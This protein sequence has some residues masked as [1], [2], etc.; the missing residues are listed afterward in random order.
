MAK[1]K[2]SKKSSRG[3][4]YD[5]GAALQ[6]IKDNP[7]LMK[8]AGN[9]MGSQGAG[10]NNTAQ[11]Q[12]NIDKRFPGTKPIYGTE[13]NLP[14][15]SKVS[16]LTDAMR[17]FTN[18]EKPSLY[19]K[20]G[21]SYEGGGGMAGIG[22]FD[23]VADVGAQ[24]IRD[25][26]GPDMSSYYNK[27]KQVANTTFGGS[28]TDDVVE[29]YN[30]M[31]R[32]NHVKR[33]DITG[34]S[35]LTDV[36]GGLNQN[37]A[38]FGKGYMATQNF[39]AAGAIAAVDLIGQI[40]K[41]FNTGRKKRRLNR[42]I[43][44]ANNRQAV[45]LNNSIDNVDTAN[46]QAILENYIGAYG[47]PIHIAKSK[48]GTFTAAANKHN[49][50]VQEFA[51]KVLAN[52]DNYSPA[53]V[54]KANFARNAAKWH[55]FGGPIDDFTNGVTIIDNG[56]THEAN[57]YNGVPMGVAPDGQPN[58][59]EEG[60][61][62][63]KDY[64]YSNRLKVP[65]AVRQKYK[66]RGPKDMTFAE[67][68]K[69]AQKESSERPNDPISKNGL[70][71]SAQILAAA[72]EG[73]K[74]DMKNKA[75]KK[76]AKGG[77]LFAYGD[78]PYYPY[79][80]STDNIEVYRAVDAYNNSEDSEDSVES[81]DSDVKTSAITRPVPITPVTTGKSKINDTLGIIKSKYSNKEALKSKIDRGLAEYTSRGDR[82]S[83]KADLSALRY[84][85]T[86][87]NAGAVLSD[88]LGYTNRPHL[89][90][91]VP[92]AP[93]IRHSPLGNYLPKMSIDTRY[94]ANALAQQAAA[95]R[96]ALMQSNSPSRNAAILAADFNAQTQLGDLLRKDQLSQYDLDIKRAEFNR[97]TDQANSQMGLTAAEANARNLL[98]VAQMAM[99]QDEYN[100]KRKLA[101]GM[102]KS[103]NAKALAENIS[104][105]GREADAI[106]W[107]DMYIKFGPALPDYMRPSG[108]TDEEWA[109]CK[110]SY[111]DGYKENITKAKKTKACGGKIRR[112]NKGFTF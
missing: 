34:G 112:R 99:Q 77:H 12:R 43:D 101:A 81:T 63:F 31:R 111:A 2:C 53:M 97:G 24:A 14:I 23:V 10:N 22:T 61:A 106:K 84:F 69:S 32:L 44:Y 60:E 64:V 49:M 29:Q 46:D 110:K 79:E 28:T 37:A 11:T 16:N 40:G 67:A 88:A 83:K 76:F 17:T 82:S 45:S 75:I 71:S 55:A 102:A 1:K 95:T 104:N 87:A 18:D 94:N 38:A 96:R 68:F 90:D 8:A 65:K 6:F 41:W 19:D 51:S 36:I 72:Q 47:G 93:V 57:P 100:D 42:L 52:K 91:E 98:Q 105:L 59:V 13:E 108:W 5:W 7:E 80:D 21:Y 89:M 26:N 30:N 54:K 50:G 39:Y 85:S 66:L 58:L 56:N 109:E 70:N 20:I 62:I 35:Y 78:P 3:H 86:L 73:V 27:T 92:P 33:H 9:M 15:V 25:F 107:R 48:E 103:A 74:E 4:R